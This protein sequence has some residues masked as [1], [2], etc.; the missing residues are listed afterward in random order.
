M[1]LSPKQ[2][3]SLNMNRDI[4]L[5]YIIA[6]EYCDSI[7]LANT[8]DKVVNYG[9]IVLHYLWMFAL[10]FIV[11]FWLFFLL[12]AKSNAS[13]EETYKQD[14]FLDRF[15]KENTI[16]GC[17]NSITKTTREDNV[18]TQKGDHNIILPAREQ[19][20]EWLKYYNE[21]QIVNRLALVN[22]ESAFREN[23]WNPSAYWYVQT[24]RSH[25]VAPDIN[26][27]LS[28][29]KNRENKTYWQ[30]YFNWKSGLLKW[31]GYYWENENTRDWTWKWEYWVLSCMYR[32]HYSQT[33]GVWY[34]KRWIIAT[35]FYKSYMYWIE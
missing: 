13:Y 35:K 23:V 29:L 10:A 12:Y 28:W 5:K 34:A 27:Q 1:I 7:E 11:S 26:S 4:N 21:A 9:Y 18:C 24:L 30:E 16:I 8:K 3:K 14:R 25:K 15:P 32:F 19:I 33:E 6:R 31:C 22:F 17:Y 20:K 2:A